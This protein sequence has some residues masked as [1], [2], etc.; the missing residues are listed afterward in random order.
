MTVFGVISLWYFESKLTL[1]DGLGLA[2]ISR[3]VALSLLQ[4]F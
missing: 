1:S 4:P 2:L 3:P